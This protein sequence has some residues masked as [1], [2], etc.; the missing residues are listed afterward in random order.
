MRLCLEGNHPSKRKLLKMRSL[1]VQELATVV[2]SPSFE[3]KEQVN[4]TDFWRVGMNVVVI[5]S[6]PENLTS[7]GIDQ[8]LMG[9]YRT[10]S[11]TFQSI[12]L[13]CGSPMFLRFFKLLN[14]D[15]R[16]IR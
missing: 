1:R 15:F 16:M 9:S 3:M 6:F 8:F 7:S 14:T 11:H 4:E 5:V 13:I 2:S 12:M 10:I